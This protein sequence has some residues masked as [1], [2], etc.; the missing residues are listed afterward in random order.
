MKSCWALHYARSHCDVVKRSLIR[1]IMNMMFELRLSH[2]RETRQDFLVAAA[3]LPHP[4]RSTLIYVDNNLKVTMSAAAPE[5]PRQ[6]PP[7]TRSQSPDASPS[8]Y[9]EAAA[10]GDATPQNGSEESLSRPN[11]LHYVLHMT[12]RGHKRGVAAVKFSPDG[13]WIASCCMQILPILR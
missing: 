7:R 4:R 5:T 9:D 2:V 13:R 1:S 10:A 8:Q 11:E 3:R 6:S 12:L